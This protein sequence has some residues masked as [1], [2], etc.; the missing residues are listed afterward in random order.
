[1][2]SGVNARTDRIWALPLF[3]RETVLAGLCNGQGAK[4]LETS[5]VGTQVAL[6]E[7]SM[8]ASAFTR[9]GITNIHGE[10]IERALRGRYWL[11]AALMA[12]KQG[13]IMMNTAY[14]IEQSGTDSSGE[15]SVSPGTVKDRI[16]LL[17]ESVPRHVEGGVS[18]PVVKVKDADGPRG[19]EADCYTF[20]N[21]LRGWVYALL[22]SL[23]LW[24][25]V[26]GM[27]YSLVKR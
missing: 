18:L 14:P 21:A 25:I 3:G 23:V 26:I 8:N 15:D 11:N 5:W 6:C 1:M 22:P 9:E 24:A 16:D 10:N 19:R 17:R 2:A 20:G 27:T 12:T 13:L 4:T 7:V